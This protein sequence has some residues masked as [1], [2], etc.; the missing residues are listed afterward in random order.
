MRPADEGRVVRLGRD[1]TMDLVI[2][3]DNGQVS[4]HHVDVTE[5]PDGRLL[6]TDQGSTNGTFLNDDRLPVGVPAAMSLQ[7]RVCFGS[8]MFN[9]ALLRGHLQFA[10]R[11]DS[12]VAPP[13]PRGRAAQPD[14]AQPWA[15]MAPPAPPGGELVP[16]PNSLLVPMAITGGLIVL[17]ALIGLY[18]ALK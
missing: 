9:T 12:L 1:H 11:L 4:R 14:P 16:Q 7:D 13:S 6:I 2:A 18:F 15:A 8:Y 3:E 17:C 5:Y 10:H